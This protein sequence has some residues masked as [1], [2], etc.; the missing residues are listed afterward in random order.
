M[1]IRSQFIHNST[2]RRLAKSFESTAAFFSRKLSDWQ[3]RE[4]FARF[5]QIYERVSLMLKVR[6]WTNE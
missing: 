3:G 4:T 1:E 5:G 6:I 2:L